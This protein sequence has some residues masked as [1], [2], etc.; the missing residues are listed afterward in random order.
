MLLG[1]SEQGTAACA[2]LPQGDASRPGDCSILKL[3]TILAVVDSQQRHLR[4]IQAELDRLRQ[5]NAAAKL[6]PETR[7]K[8][9]HIFDG[10]E[11]QFGKTTQLRREMDKLGVDQSLKD[12]TESDRA[13]VYCSATTSLSRLLDVQGVTPQSI[14]PMIERNNAMKGQ[15]EQTG[16]AVDCRTFAATPFTLPIQPP[17]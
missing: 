8:L 16:R 17:D 12:T 4:A 9:E 5:A 6:P 7:P 14:Q 11:T 13:V 3:A 1:A 15:I 10:F 2:R